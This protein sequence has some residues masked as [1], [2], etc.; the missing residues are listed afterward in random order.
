M[1]DRL[2]KI[3]KAESD[4]G[5]L[6]ILVI[7]SVIIQFIL[8]EFGD[9]IIS[10]IIHFV[11]SWVVAYIFTKIFK[12]NN[13]SLVQWWKRFYIIIIIGSIISYLFF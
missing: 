2:F 11:A 10:S 7:I 9:A 4:S 6:G 5:Q 12:D 13:F 8:S 1:F 3:F